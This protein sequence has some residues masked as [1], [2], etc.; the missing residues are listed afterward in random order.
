MASTAAAGDWFSGGAKAALAANAQVA[1][2]SM[3]T[4]IAAEANGTVMRAS[5]AGCSA[6]CDDTGVSTTIG[7]SSANISAFLT[8]DSAICSRPITSAIR[9]GESFTPL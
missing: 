1:A 8:C 5:H 9:G 7:N 2:P 4:T 3:T 6:N